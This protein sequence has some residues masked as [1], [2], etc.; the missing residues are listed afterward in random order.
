MRRKLKR[1]FAWLGTCL[2]LFSSTTAYCAPLPMK[3]ESQEIIKPEIIPY[4]KIDLSE[5]IYEPPESDPVGVVI[6][7]VLADE[8]PM[9]ETVISEED[10]ELLAIVTMAEAEG[11]PEE[12]QRLVID[13][14]LNRMDSPY[15]PDTVYDVVYQPGQFTSMWNGRADRCYVKDDILAL[16]YEEAD[17]RTNSE[18]VFFRTRHYSTYGVPMFQVGHHY[19]SK[20]E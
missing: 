16:V 14:I 5:L 18:V 17:S 15:F 10:A 12:G 11:E 6:H 9:P 3:N 7:E 2:F 1:V 4:E 19:F 8:K 13:T 20:Y